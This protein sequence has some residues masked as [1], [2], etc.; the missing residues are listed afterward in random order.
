[1]ADV[2]ACIDSINEALVLAAN[3]GETEAA[4]INTGTSS[5]NIVDVLILLLCDIAA[6]E[7]EGLEREGSVSNAEE[8]QRISLNTGNEEDYTCERGGVNMGTG[9]NTDE[10]E[11][12]SVNRHKDETKVEYE[13]DGLIRSAMDDREENHDCNAREN[14]HQKS[15]EISINNKSVMSEVKDAGERVES[16]SENSTKNISRPVTKEEEVMD[17]LSTMIPTTPPSP[18]RVPTVDTTSTSA[19]TLPSSKLRLMEQR[20]FNSRLY[21]RITMI[22]DVMPRF[23]YSGI[24]NFALIQFTVAFSF[25]L[26]LDL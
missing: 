17:H 19:C 9:E 13:G 18:L 7:R 3:E 5:D 24:E 6:G 14:D 23:M 2:L 25:L 10:V 20:C 12:D 8:K 21:S 15:N 11:K 1:M 22:T 16:M 26:K 4:G